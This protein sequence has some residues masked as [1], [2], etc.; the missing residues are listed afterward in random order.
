MLQPAGSFGIGVTNPVTKLDVYGDIQ[1][2]GFVTAGTFLYGD[3]S[4]ITNLPSDS[5]WIQTSAGIHTIS[6]N[7]LVRPIPEFSVD[8]RGGAAGND[9]DLFVNGLAKF[10]GI[11][12]FDSSAIVSG[13]FTATDFR[14]LDSDG[15]ITAGIATINQFINVGA[16]GTVFLTTDAGKVGINSSTI[17]NQARVDIGRTKINDLFSKVVTVTSSAGIATLDL[18]SGRNFKITTTENIT[19]FVLSNRLDSDDHTSFTLK[20]VQGSTAR[21]V[22]VNTFKQ[23]TG[24]TAIPV[25]WSGGV[26]P[27]VVNVGLKTDI[28]SFQTFDGGASL[29]GVVVGQNFS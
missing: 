6:T 28:Y 15:I 19:E 24:G 3:G 21:G 7:V 17:D 10:N 27:T 2:T 16:S 25:S 14:L 29:Y 23:T 11:T 4:R 5:L 8:I 20:I 9:G 12:Q 26:L 1:A 22:G 13:I 18:S